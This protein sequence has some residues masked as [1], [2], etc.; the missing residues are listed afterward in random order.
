MFKH[1]T[2]SVNK[3]RIEE[4]KKKIKNEISKLKR[5]RDTPQMSHVDVLSIPKHQISMLALLKI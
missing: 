3:A 2:L 4:K 1:H 5:K